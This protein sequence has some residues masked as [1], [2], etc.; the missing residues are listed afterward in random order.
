MDNFKLLKIAAQNK[1]LEIAQLLTENFS[2]KHFEPNDNF[3]L[4]EEA[5]ESRNVQ[6]AKIVVVNIAKK[7]KLDN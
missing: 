3:K 7:R 1:N 5:A 2:N 4:L 6:V